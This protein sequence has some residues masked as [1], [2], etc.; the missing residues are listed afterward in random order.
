MRISRD[1]I[2]ARVKG[3]LPITF[4]DEKISAHGGL[5]LVRRYLAAIDLPRRLRALFRDTALDG[6]FGAVRIA[7]LLI[8]LLVI[9]GLRV[10]HLAFVGTDPILLR[11]A[12]LHFAPADRTVVRWLKAFTP[13][14]LERLGALIRDLVYEQIER[15]RLARLTIDLDGTVL[16]TGAHVD[17]AERGFNP[18]HPK[19]RSY[20]PL[21]AH[22]A[23][24]GHILRV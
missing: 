20:Y 1:R 23:Q 22:L 11:F 16:R 17:G 21:T 19:D 3:N 13:P 4:S 12:G 6:D 24:T 15:C 5:E 7:L 18:H 2:R 10:T 9:G 14:A 8:G